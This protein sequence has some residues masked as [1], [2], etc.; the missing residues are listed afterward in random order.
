MMRAH[1][2]ARTG[3]C[4]IVYYRRRHLGPGVGRSHASSA[5]VVTS[6]R[7]SRPRHLHRHARRRPSSSPTSS[8][9]TT[10]GSAPSISQLGPDGA[11]YIADFY[12]R[13]IGHYEVPL[14]HP[15]RDRERGR[16]WRVVKDGR[17]RPYRKTFTAMGAKNIADELGNPNLTRRHL[18]LREVKQRGTRDWLPDL[19]QRL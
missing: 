4:G 12:N 15:G 10:P 5:T 1:A 11:L 13:I 16:I 19:T 3:I 9:A 18:A 7:Q 8:P 17:Q 14:D 6:P 2:T